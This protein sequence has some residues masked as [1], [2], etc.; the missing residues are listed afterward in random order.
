MT[1]TK[2]TEAQTPAVR[3]LQAA[4]MAGFM[5]SGEGYNGEYPHGTEEQYLSSDGWVSMRDRDLAAL[6][7]DMANPITEPA[8]MQ[9]WQPI[10]T[11]PKEE[12][13]DII[14]FNGKDVQCAQWW[15]GGWIDSSLD[16]MVEQP[17]H[18]MPLPSAPDA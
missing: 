17:T 5:A 16:W 7:V 8:P 11:A 14:V 3:S 1:D 10:E 2:D 18:W 13:K 9:V 12:L 6:E 15:E 4:Y